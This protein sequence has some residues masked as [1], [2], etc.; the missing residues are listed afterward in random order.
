MRRW[1]IALGLGA[2]L[3]LA[4]YARLAQRPAAR[5]AASGGCGALRGAVAAGMPPLLVLHMVD[6]CDGW[7]FTRM[8]VYR[9]SDGGTRWSNVS[10]PRAAPTQP[11]A[12]ASRPAPW[13]ATDGEH[14]WRVY[15]L[16]RAGH[17]LEIERTANGGKAWRSAALV[18][19]GG[20][21]GVEHAALWFVNP[22][23]GFLAAVAGAGGVWHALSVFRTRDG[24]ARWRQVGTVHSSQSA[25]SGARAGSAPP[26]G[27][28]SVST[29]WN[30]SGL[31]MVL[32]G[33]PGNP[34]VLTTTD[35]GTV[36][37]RRVLPAVTR[38]RHAWRL[39]PGGVRGKS[40]SIL[41]SG[42]EANG[43]T[44]ALVDHTGDRGRTWRAGQAITA[45]TLGFFASFPSPEQG[46][47]T[48][49]GRLFRTTDGGA[50]WTSFVPNRNLDGITQLDFVSPT[51]GFALMGTPTGTGLLRTTDGGHT[52]AVV[53]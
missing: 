19:P 5:P 49:G 29:M 43:A 15:G 33:C 42:N 3:A 4:G 16:Y 39:A 22:E 36:W 11:T 34:G 31:G 18:V 44:T 24:G 41:A 8:G 37:K 12:A 7:G 52:W 20:G 47:L 30:R 48:G 45:H 32:A 51:L 25:R 23:V 50:H 38:T 27:C 53:R 40:A 9:T 6:A 2:S 46:F 13:F 21:A 10:P 35:G 17:P 1:V 14:A 26:P 28:R